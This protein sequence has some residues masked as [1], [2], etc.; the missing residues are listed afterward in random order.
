MPDVL[1][2]TDALSKAEANELSDVD[3]GWVSIVKRGA[4]RIPIR[5]MKS[6]DDMLSLNLS[7]LF[8]KA[9]GLPGVVAVA[10]SKGADI[11]SA[12]ARIEKAGLSVADQR[13]HD[14]GVTLF[15]QPGENLEQ[16]DL[17][18][19][20]IDDAMAVVVK[21]AGLK[22]TFSDYNFESTEFKE[23]MGQEGF[24]PSLSAAH[25]VLGATISNIMQKADDA[26]AAKE[27][28]SKA[29]GDFG[30]FVAGLVGSIPITAF[31][32]EADE[33]SPAPVKKT[34]D[35]KPVD[36]ADGGG[37]DEG[38]DGG[39]K[40]GDV[41]KT[42][43]DPDEDPDKKAAH[44]KDKGKS[45]KADDAG[46]TAADDDEPAPDANAA[47]L[48]QILQGIGSLQE[49]VGTIAKTVD[50]QGTRL[51]QVA[52]DAQSAMDTAKKADEAASGI[53]PSDTRGDDTPAPN[54][55]GG[56]GHALLDTGRMNKADREKAG[57][58]IGATH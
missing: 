52:K 51:E 57:I 40:D 11:D 33:D 20:Q 13:E 23:V 17:E 21:N 45:K 24:F 43:A 4:N 47:Q 54:S 1:I 49:T 32:L 55:G 28:I 10:V 36:K 25:G 58:A 6:E 9:D 35:K 42:D 37:D 44:G 22:K 56:S 34:D 18:P 19:V 2:R 15:V 3:V 8:S 46:G 31:K 12:K 5:I 30:M 48:G 41:K 7:N 29:I 16:P 38:S 14:D 53:V 27:Q 50:S 26:G 39:P